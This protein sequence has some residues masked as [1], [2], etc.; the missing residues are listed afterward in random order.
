MSAGHHRVVL[1]TDKFKGSATAVE[2]ARA[3]AAGL[4]RT[5]PGTDVVHAPVADGGEGTLDAALAAGWARVAV[6]ATGPTGAPVATAYARDGVRALVELADVS[7]LAR[8]PEGPRPLD[9]STLGAGEVLAAAV[10]AGCRQ[11]V[12][13]VGGSAS[14]DGG[15]G[16][17]QGLGA[18]LLDADGRP[19]RPG[20]RHLLGLAEV[21]LGP[22]RR[23]LDGV[24]VTL[25]SDVDNPLLGPHGA[26]AVYGPQKGAGP[27]DVALL[28][29]ALARWADVLAGAVG[30]DLRGE[31]GA[32]AAGGTGFAAIAALGAAQQ[33]GVETVLELTGF[34]ALAA[35][36]DLVVTGEGSLDQQSLHGK[37]PVGVARAARRLGVPVVAVCGRQALSPAE[38][39][40]VGIDACWSLV[41]REPDARRCLREA[42]RLLEEVGAE[43]GRYLGGVRERTPR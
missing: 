10:S 38:L 16:L 29:R 24:V 37:T 25:A 42:P 15:A 39:R 27:D 19:L 23:L 28:E 26:A 4:A 33:P 40:A 31:P 34:D 32:G 14:T 43:I 5:A 17:L 35:A 1:A 22:V 20:G 12:L 21:D 11:V 3:L 36:A 7:G 41:D 18:R 2:V 13:G 30:G 9:A 8:L 6:T